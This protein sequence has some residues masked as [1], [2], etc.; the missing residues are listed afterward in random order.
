MCAPAAESTNIVASKSKLTKLA[1]KRLERFV[2]LFAKVLVSDTPET[3]HDVRVASRRLQQT[4]RSFVP[5]SKASKAQKLNRILRKLRRA[6]GACRNFDVSIALIEKRR[7][8]V[9]AAS[10]RRA[11]E[12]VQQSLEEQ[13]TKAIADGR[14]KLKHCPLIDLIERAQSCIEAID[15]QP[16]IA[17]QLNQRVAD[18]LTAWNETLAAAKA[19]PETDNLH[20]FRIAGKRLRYRIESRAELGDA[21]VKPL[22]QGLKLLQDDLGAWHDRQVLQQNA[23]TF[24]ERSG[25]LTREPGLCRSL[26]L[27]MERDKQ[28]DQNMVEEIL[29][30]A[31]NLAAEWTEIEAPEAP[32]ADK[33]IAR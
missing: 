2:T 21:S 6:L 1:H 17:V 8:T 12:A 10:L 29:G 14:V 18:A 9:A 24:I 13:R 31:E 11:W 27:E 30:K 26:L 25:F 4:L 28:R 20:A 3:I 16:E 15:D 33:S 5:K 19:N 7:A 23:G 32:A 22:V